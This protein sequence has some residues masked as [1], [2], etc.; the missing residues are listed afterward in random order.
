MTGS[1]V[2]ILFAAP[3]FLKLK[4]PSFASGIATASIGNAALPKRMLLC[5]APHRAL[6]RSV[7]FGMPRLKQP[8]APARYRESSSSTQRRPIGQPFSVS[9]DL[10]R[11]SRRLQECERRSELSS[12]TCASPQEALSWHHQA[13]TSSTRSIQAEK[14]LLWGS[15]APPFE[16]TPLLA[17]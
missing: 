9:S 14:L 5:G 8:G 6:S 12:P 11:L 4:R 7:G 3:L 2:R 17:L 16:A 1:Q 13:P 10:A 15:R